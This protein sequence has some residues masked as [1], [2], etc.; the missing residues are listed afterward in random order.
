MKEYFSFILLNFYLSFKL[1]SSTFLLVLF[2][3]IYGGN[4]NGLWFLFYMCIHIFTPSAILL[5]V[6]YTIWR[7]MWKYVFFFKDEHRYRNCYKRVCRCKITNATIVKSQVTKIRMVLKESERCVQRTRHVT[8]E[9]VNL[10]VH[11]KW[12]SLTLKSPL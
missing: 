11:R 8:K 1:S 5:F 10:F 12:F 6:C 3:F 7:W 9:S 4:N 2:S